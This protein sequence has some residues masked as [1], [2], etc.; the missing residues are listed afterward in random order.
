MEV[1]LNSKIVRETL[2]TKGYDLKQVEMGSATIGE[3]LRRLLESL[4]DDR[5]VVQTNDKDEPDFSILRRDEAAHGE[6]SLK[7]K[8]LDGKD[9]VQSLAEILRQILRDFIPEEILRQTMVRR[10]KMTFNGEAEHL[11]LG[12]ESG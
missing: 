4:A 8:Q 9:V 2:K 12:Q 5:P 3:D 11:G 6:D 10:K 1:M 7:E